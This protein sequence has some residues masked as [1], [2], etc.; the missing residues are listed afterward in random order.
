MS[1]Q[2][3]NGRETLPAP[4]GDVVEFS[5]V[6]ARVRRV[7]GHLAAVMSPG[8]GTRSP[9]HGEILALLDELSSALSAERIAQRVASVLS[10]R[11]VHLAAIAP[12]FD[13]R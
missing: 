4:D 13:H 7:D 5:I 12:R 11:R 9:S 3:G 6:L 1:E 2:D 8:G 10:E